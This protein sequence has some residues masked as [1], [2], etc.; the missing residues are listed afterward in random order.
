MLEDVNS[1]MPLDELR[2]ELALL[3]E[4]AFTSIS[5]EELLAR[6]RRMQKG[7]RFSAPIFHPGTTIFRAVRVAEKPF[8][9]ARLSYPPLDRIHVNGRLNRA[10]EAVF[11]GSLGDFGPCLCECRC[12]E[13]ENFAV[14]VW[15]TMKPIT[16]SHLGYSRKTVD[17]LNVKR[18]LP[19]WTESKHD[20]ERNALIRAWQARVFTRIIPEGE[21]HLYRLGLAFRIFALGSMVQTDSNLPDFF[22]GVTYP[23]ISMWLLGDNVALLPSVVDSSLSL[24]EVIFLTVQSIVESPLKDG[25]KRTYNTRFIDFARAFRVDGRLVWNGESTALSVSPCSVPA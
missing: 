13:G 25:K 23:T 4:G 6:I 22:A 18:D 14:S 10:G 7:F 24:H 16:L 1:L 20:T 15:K 2:A 8:Y 21:E 11:Y 12:A 3:E 17:Q 5:D 19:S 9:K